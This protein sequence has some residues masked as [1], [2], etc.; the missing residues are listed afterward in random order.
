[1]LI[2]VVDP[3]VMGVLIRIFARKDEEEFHNLIFTCV[4]VYVLNVLLYMSLPEHLTFYRPL[5][6]A[7]IN[8]VIVEWVFRMGLLKL[9]VFAA[10]FAG[11]KLGAYF[12]YLK[13]LS[14]YVLI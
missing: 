12:L 1:M 6:A 14:D 3:V 7:G 9:L 4:V 5:I 10:L 11:Y 8:M 13:Y 2:V